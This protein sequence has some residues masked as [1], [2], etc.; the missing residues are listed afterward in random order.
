LKLQ[1]LEEKS[2]RELALRAAAL[3]RKAAELKKRERLL[4]NGSITSTL[5]KENTF[6]DLSSI[7]KDEE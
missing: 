2:A 3:E 4:R 1:E 5:K 7:V 6:T